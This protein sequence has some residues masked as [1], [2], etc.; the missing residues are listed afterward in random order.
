M[1]S[2]LPDSW[3]YQ[4]KDAK[5]ILPEG[6]SILERGPVVEITSAMD[7]PEKLDPP[8]MRFLTRFTRDIA[9]AS[10]HYQFGLDFK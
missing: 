4:F 1:K 8:F 5:V 7:L 9:I 2:D 3:K 6:P 10:Y